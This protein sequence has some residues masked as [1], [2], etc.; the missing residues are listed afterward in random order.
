[1]EI[2]GLNEL[3]STLEKGDSNTLITLYLYNFDPSEENLLSTL[4]KILAEQEQKN[5]E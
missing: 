5:D 3:K 1:M 2:F 4:S